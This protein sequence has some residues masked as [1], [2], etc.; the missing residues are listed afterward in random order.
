MLLIVNWV[1]IIEKK[2][3]LIFKEKTNKLMISL[4]TSNT[5]KKKSI[6]KQMKEVQQLHQKHSTDISKK[7][8]DLMT[9]LIHLE[10]I[11]MDRKTTSNTLPSVN[12]NKP[13][14]NIGSKPLIDAQGQTIHNATYQADLSNNRK[15]N[16]QSFQIYF[17]YL[18]SCDLI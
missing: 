8:Q 15:E 12:N 16:K 3:H 18:T 5:T 7:R 13:N 10:N 11:V 17:E 6:L 14:T 9:K 4:K 2:H 1:E